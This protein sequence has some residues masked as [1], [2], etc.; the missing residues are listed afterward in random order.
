VN[1]SKA[2]GLALAALLAAPVAA[3]VPGQITVA[4][5]SISGDWGTGVDTDRRSALVRFVWGGKTRLRGDLEFLNV[6]SDGPL[7]VQ[8]P[9]G[10][11]AAGQRSGPGPGGSG[12]GSGGSGSGSGPGGP[13]DSTGPPGEPATGVGTEER[14]S[15][16]GD[17]RLGVEQTLLGGGGRL[18]RLDAEFGVKVPT[19]DEEEYLG[20]G[21]WDYRIGLGSEYQLW[22]G[23]L[24]AGAGWNRLGDPAWTV[25]EDV[26]DA[27]VGMASDPLAGGLVVAGWLEGNQEVLAGAGDRTAVGLSLRGSGRLR[28]GFELT[29]GLGGSAEDLSV[30]FGLSLGADLLRAGRRGG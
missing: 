26:L 15:G 19:A 13:G 1:A 17:L 28:W 23:K 27:Y 11:V 2:L 30:A 3:E 8:T 29:A 20:S 4:A 14:S 9:F 21:E 24:F 18:F 12:S 25:L 16:V 5:S 22:T 10:P 6:R 7:V